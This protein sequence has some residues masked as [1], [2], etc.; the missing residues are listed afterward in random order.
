MTTTTLPCFH[1]H[2]LRGTFER[3]MSIAR[4]ND[5]LSLDEHD[6]LLQLCLT[7][8]QPPAQLRI[9][10]IE[11]SGWSNHEFADALMIS[12]V[13]TTIDA[14]YLSLPLRAIERFSD[15]QSLN[16][17]LHARYAEGGGIDISIEQ[18][19]TSPFDYWMANLLSRQQRCVERLD[20]TLMKLP[21]LR[22]VLLDT[23]Q[24]DIAQ[25][26][27]SGDTDP[28]HWAW[29]VNQL[30]QPAVN[31]QTRSLLDVALDK[32]CAIREPDP[33]RLTLLNAQGDVLAPI[34]QQR[35]TQ[36][37][38]YSINRLNSQVD[39]AIT[40]FWQRTGDD[41]LTYSAQAAGAL[42]HL[43]YLALLR[44]EQLG[45]IATA[46]LLWL[47]NAQGPLARQT[48]LRTHSITLHSGQRA[49]I[50]LA[51]LFALT[52]NDAV[53]QG[54]YLFCARSGLH[55]F[56][57]P[58]ALVD[59]LTGPDQQLLLREAIG[60]ENYAPYTR[61]KRIEA[62]LADIVGDTFAD[63]V[64]SVVAVQRAN[65]S[66]AIAQR[67]E[68]PEQSAT[69]LDDAIDVRGLLVPSLLNLT[70]STRWAAEPRSNVDQGGATAGVD[71]LTY[72]YTLLKVGDL[73]AWSSLIRA[74][75]PGL[76][77]CLVYLIDRQLALMGLPALECTQLQVT[78]PST[79]NNLQSVAEP[80]LA[81]VVNHLGNSPPAPL[82]EDCIVSTTRG[83]VL[84]C[85]DARLLNQVVTRVA[86]GAHYS[87]IR[88]FDRY[89]RQPQRIGN[90]QIDTHAQLSAMRQ[91]ILR[92]ELE[93]ASIDSKST[94]WVHV[95]LRQVLD[96]PTRAMRQNLGDTQVEVN[97]INLR[98]PGIAFAIPLSNVMALTLARESPGKILFCS[99]VAGVMTFANLAEFELEVN[100]LMR[101][102]A[103]RESWLA[104]VADRY[105]SGLRANLYD[106]KAEPVALELAAVEDDYAQYLQR[107]DETRQVFNAQAAFNRA[108]GGAYPPDLLLAYVD[109][110]AAPMAL[111]TPLNEL[112]NTLKGNSLLGTLPA[113]ITK[114]S[115]ADLGLY[116]ANLHRLRIS[117]A[118]PTGYLYGVE[119]AVDYATEQLWTALKL[120]FPADDIDPTQVMVRVDQRFPTGLHFSG[121]SA[122]LMISGGESYPALTM[123]LVEYSLQRAITVPGLPIE[124]SM[125]DHSGV[126][127][128]LTPAYVMQ[129][130][131]GLD[132]GGRYLRRLAGTFSP[133]NPNYQ[134]RLS[135][136]HQ[137][138]PATL[139]DGAIEAKLCGALSVAAYQIVESVLEMPD[140]LARQVPSGAHRSLRPLCLLAGKGL[141]PDPVAGLY[142][143][144]GLPTVTGPLVLM[145]IYNEAFIFREYRDEQD[146]MAKLRAKGDLQ[147]LVLQRI[148]PARIARYSH[149]GL[150][151]A[152]LQAS[153]GAP[154]EQP[155][156]RPEQTWITYE[157]I[158]GN[159]F[160]YLFE[161]ALAF[162]LRQA[163]AQIVTSDQADHA[164]NATLLKLL[165]ETGLSF[166]NGRVALA[167]G[168][169]QGADWLRSSVT[170]AI[171]Q[172][173]GRA[174]AQ[175]GASIM[176]IMTQR[177][178]RHTRT[179]VTQ[180]TIER[181]PARVPEYA[182]RFNDIPNDI[183]AR[184]RALEVHDI[185]LATL[186]KDSTAGVFI[187]IA[188]QKRY[189]PIAGM[190]FEVRNLD[191][192]WSIVSEGREGP[193]LRRN[194]QGQLQMDLGTGLRGGGGGWSAQRRERK[195]QRALD[196]AY[197][198]EARG[199]P[200]IRLNYPAYARRLAAARLR[201]KVYLERCMDALAI[202]LGQTQIPAASND[203]LKDFFAV[204]APG[205]ALINQVRE[206]SAGL[207]AELMDAS[208]NTYTSTR[209][210]S[211]I[212]KPGYE[213]VI[214]FVDNADPY[215][216]IFL[217]DM[218]FN[219]PRVLRKTLHS[220]HR[221]FDVEEHFRA[222]SL[223]HEL[224]H[225]VCDTADLAYVESS[226]PYLDMIDSTAPDGQALVSTITRARNQ[227]LNAHTPEAELFTLLDNGVRRDISKA[228]GD[229]YAHVLRI[230]K[231]KTLDDARSAFVADEA[232]R[233]QILL[234]NADSVALLITLL[235]R[236]KPKT[237]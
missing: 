206:M 211:G 50:A 19:S 123:S 125:R 21:T 118:M 200:Q 142:L 139:M 43:Y 13:D 17:A 101:D 141:T 163:R 192:T 56:P 162:L 22:S 26:T 131:S 48:T 76:R 220:S 177:Y 190:V 110:I 153:V 59:W 174:V 223:I 77:A 170:A 130:V 172:D 161:S 93:L 90:T 182:S 221:S 157:P 207:F 184:L 156:P 62:R 159:T 227:S 222:T 96:R 103:G 167:V 128:G 201:A 63:R 183:R 38:N 40:T 229:A 67:A 109:E 37:F 179:R 24:A 213:W 82:P 102:P 150:T 204:A 57:H 112:A 236:Q 143:L 80:L 215:R 151:V 85:V 97:R 193:I 42:A 41:T 89:T 168:L 230:S 10:R 135:L 144:G 18:L 86:R 191:G 202:P 199:M 196:T 127:E 88:Q 15:R 212:N 91:Q 66:I 65:L 35:Y 79:D 133:S 47:R 6:R 60:K 218:F 9:D 54:L 116:L 145:A 233:Q 99:H 210:V 25:L 45:K 160:T 115:F 104:L 217:T 33:K 119:S 51:G 32:F 122:D 11:A 154:F 69:R 169:W 197:I 129:M 121:A 4:A 195:L 105:Q 72:D 180:A 146:F 155:L 166:V 165:L 147:D 34:E 64:S 134:Q 126:V 20:D 75:Q 164:A 181:P 28:T 185:A 138:V 39:E 173:W 95:W 113:W 71:N 23:L 117:L 228:D 5:E 178:P 225:L 214:A 98:V 205:D 94:P 140:P 53:D 36:L 49:G 58:Q 137:Q 216:R 231:R 237:H 152:N 106:E 46:D 194:A 29:H 235:A 203:I 189:S 78:R 149:G 74:T 52:S 148:D 83:E 14:V 111:A 68:S 31:L 176:I 234:A 73:Q 30:T 198:T 8:W 44:A 209:Y 55:Y 120:D 61:M 12:H 188:T 92:A 171:A 27:P 16:T 232:V 1:T 87:W 136:F 219:V 132:T 124:L 187:D 84:S 158:R 2:V 107:S 226:A 208:L 81:L 114:A 175:L 186:T 3:Q 100:R 7:P 108:R 224:S 70:H